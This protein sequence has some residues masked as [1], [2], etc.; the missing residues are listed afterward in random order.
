MEPARSR[1]QAAGEAAWGQRPPGVLAAPDGTTGAAG[2]WYWRLC[3]AYCQHSTAQPSSSYV[4]WGCICWPRDWRLPFPT[5]DPLFAR[6]PWPSKTI[7]KRIY[8]YAGFDM[9]FEGGQWGGVNTSTEEKK[10]KTQALKNRLLETC[11]KIPLA[12]GISLF[13][14]LQ[15]C[16]PVL[17][18]AGD[19]LLQATVFEQGCWHR[20]ALQH[21]QQQPQH[22]ALPV[23]LRPP[24]SSFPSQDAASRNLY[25]L[26]VDNIATRMLSSIVSA[27]YSPRWAAHLF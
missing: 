17:L 2:P 27:I 21:A 16:T 13:Q 24:D 20:E 10:K 5:S 14:C 18:E 6:I 25:I 23:R 12:I 1:A 19:G 8:R 9:D 26:C 15:W 4:P 7:W 11:N 22:C 3:Q